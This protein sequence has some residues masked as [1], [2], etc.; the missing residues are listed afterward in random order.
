MLNDLLPDG[1]YYRFNP[2][3]VE[4]CAMDEVNPEKLANLVADAHAYIRR[5]QFKFEQAATLLLRKRSLAQRM[6]D[7]VHLQSQVM[8]VVQN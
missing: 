5:N 2:P 3:L 8:G 4:E 1:N 7:Y 6:L